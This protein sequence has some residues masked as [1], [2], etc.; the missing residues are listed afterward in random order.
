MSIM[1]NTYNDIAN[2]GLNGTGFRNDEG[3]SPSMD[4]QHGPSGNHLIAT[5][6]W[7]KVI[8]DAT[9]GCYYLSNPVDADGIPVREYR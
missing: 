7:N 3:T 1:S 2:N 9:M 5:M 6:K 4:G 8:N